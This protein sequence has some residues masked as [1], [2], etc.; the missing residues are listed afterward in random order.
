MAM[1]KSDIGLI[2]TSSVY[3][4]EEIVG[5]QIVGKQR[6]SSDKAYIFPS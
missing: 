6:S 2:L 1:E 5:Q 4:L 3:I